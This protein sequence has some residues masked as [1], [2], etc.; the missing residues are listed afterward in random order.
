MST[1]SIPAVLVMLRL[2]LGPL[3]IVNAMTAR[4]ATLIMLAMAGGLLSDIFDGIIARRLNVATPLLRRADS[5]VDLV[6]Y[7]CVAAA[8]AITRPGLAAAWRPAVVCCLAAEGIIH[9]IHFYRFGTPAA[10]H[11]WSAKLWGLLLFA[12][13]T[14]VLLG[15]TPTGL[16]WTST[17]VGAI[18]YSESLLIVLLSAAAPVDVRGIAAV[19][20]TI[21]RTTNHRTTNHR[22]TIRRTTI[23]HP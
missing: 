13:A 6:F 1:R 21:R 17:V 5:L 16:I 15:N 4:S 10:V 7:L 19:I 14:A 11:A 12:S 22:T 2:A 20:K 18:A 3:L 8:I 23:R 9:V